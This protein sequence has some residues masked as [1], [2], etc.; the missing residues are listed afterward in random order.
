VKPGVGIATGY[1]LDDRGS[2]LG[3]YKSF[4]S[5]LQRPDRLAHQA[6]YTMGI[7]DFPWGKAAEV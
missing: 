2:T 3:R 1:V 5:T 7:V 4:F 6:S